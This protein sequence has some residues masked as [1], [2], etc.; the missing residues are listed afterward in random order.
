MVEREFTPKEE[1]EI[2]EL[3]QDLV[4]AGGKLKLTTR[5]MMKLLKPF[6]AFSEVGDLLRIGEEA[7]RRA[8][9]RLRRE[10]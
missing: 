4:K 1:K 3:T 6:S 5:A 2:E 10:I 7:Q 8:K 9:E